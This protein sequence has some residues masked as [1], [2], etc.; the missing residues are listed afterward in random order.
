MEETLALEGRA[1]YYD[2][3]GALKDVMQNHMLQVLC[4]ITM[5][6]PAT[7]AEHDLRDRRIDLLRSVRPLAAE[8]VAPADTPPRA[9]RCGRVAR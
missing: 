6:P 5:E 3:A 4:L 2:R 7:L 8:E 1:R 9:T